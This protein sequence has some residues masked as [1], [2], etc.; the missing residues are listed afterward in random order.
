MGASGEIFDSDELS[1]SAD[2]EDGVAGAGPGVEEEAATA[3]LGVGVGCERAEIGT[4]DVSVL[5]LESATGEGFVGV[6]VGCAG[7]KLGKF[8]SEEETVV[9]GAGVSEG[10]GWMD[11]EGA[12][13]CCDRVGVGVDSPAE[14]IGAASVFAKDS[15]LAGSGDAFFAPV[16][17]VGVAGAGLDVFAD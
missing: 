1:V 11:V 9:A 3:G 16:L 13:V 2:R 12:G 14:G 17:S 6:G 5:G 4:A 7:V 10:V 8:V 15:V